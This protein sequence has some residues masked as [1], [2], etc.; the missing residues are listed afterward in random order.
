MLH[1]HLCVCTAQALAL[2]ARDGDT[3]YLPAALR[4]MIPV[5]SPATF[6]YDEG[7]VTECPWTASFFFAGL[8]MERTYGLTLLLWADWLLDPPTRTYPLWET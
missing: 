6:L 7:C 1:L 2:G 4:R 5:I 8:A 3:P